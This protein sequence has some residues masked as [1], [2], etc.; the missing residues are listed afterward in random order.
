MACTEAHAL[1]YD[2]G[3]FDNLYLPRRL[4]TEIHAPHALARA[5]HQVPW[6][7]GSHWHSHQKAREDVTELDASGCKIVEVGCS[8]GAH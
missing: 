8:G 7:F 6:P 5:L 2:N 4:I 1:P 3:D